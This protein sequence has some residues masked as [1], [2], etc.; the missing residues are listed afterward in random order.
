MGF[1]SGVQ[2][3]QGAGWPN[4]I[5]LVCAESGA[6]VLVYELLGLEA[7]DRSTKMGQ[8]GPGQARHFDFGNCELV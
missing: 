6:G 2:P 5:D 7:T 3:V 4:P 1:G 8:D